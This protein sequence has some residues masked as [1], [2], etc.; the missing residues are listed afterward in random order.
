VLALRSALFNLVF[1]L[2]LG[3][4]LVLGFAFLLTPRKWSIRA[5]QAWARSTNGL[6]AGL[7]GID[8]EVRGLERIPDG[9]VLVAAKHQSAWDTFGL[10]PIFDDPAM[11][12][13]RELFWIPVHGWFSRKFGMIGVDRDA[14]PK[15]LR[16]LIAD[17]RKAVDDGRQVIIFPE[18]TRS[19]PGAAPDYKPGAAALYAGLD[20]PCLPV[21]LNSGLFWPRRQFLRH[22]GTIVVEILEPIAPG[23]PRKPFAA[24]LEERIEAATAEL[25]AESRVREGRG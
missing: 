5:L 20:V 16:R 13:K 6:M 14:G 15:A 21:A 9:H 24:M 8:V 25:V 18:G 23:M 3:L 7:C 10:L 2:N 12:M 17:A 11:V 1:Y 4:W 19:A 22:P